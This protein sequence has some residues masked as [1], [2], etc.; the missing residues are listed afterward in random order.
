[1]KH[2]ILYI[3][4]FHCLAQ[5]LDITGK[6]NGILRVQRME[7]PLIFYIYMG[8]SSCNAEMG[9][10]EEKAFEIPANEARFK[11]STLHIKEAGLTVRC[12]GS[13]VQIK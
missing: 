13:M 8:H 1:M 2:L 4:L 6:W 7:L 11:D 5:L 10:P 9:S 12:N 3:V